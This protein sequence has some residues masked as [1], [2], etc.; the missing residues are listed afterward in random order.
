[1]NEEKNPI[2]NNSSINSL[3]KR[4]EEMVKMNQ[5]LFFDVDDFENLIDYYMS[6]SKKHFTEIAIREALE[7]HPKHNGFLLKKAQHLIAVEKNMEALELLDLLE[8]SD[9]F[10][11][12]VFFIK[13]GLYSQLNKFSLAIEQYLKALTDENSSE[14]YT[15]IAYEYENLGKYSM[16]IKYLK[17]ALQHDVEDYGILY[18]LSFCF[19]ITNKHEEGIAFF[20]QF[21]D[22]YPFS[23]EAWY[24]LGMLYSSATYYEQAID[25][26]DYAL[27]IDDS[28]LSVLLSKAHAHAVSGN[29]MQSIKTYKEAIAHDGD[30]ASTLYLIGENYSNLE[31]YTKA[32]EYFEE[33]IKLDANHTDAWAGIG[34][35]KSE[36]ELPETA[37]KYIKKAIELEPYNADYWSMLAYVQNQAGHITRAISSYEKTLELDEKQPEVWMDYA[38]LLI[39]NGFMH[40][41]IEKMEKAV[42]VH[43][44]NDELMY[45]AAAY[46]ILAGEEKKAL[47]KLES[48]L[49]LNVENFTFFLDYDP[50]FRINKDIVRLIES[51]IEKSKY[52]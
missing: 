33:C 19:E 28:F 36:L 12:E 8:K 34:I 26:Y 46:L 17:K 11:S 9:P 23:K 22:Q 45:R 7:Q 6:R 25:S 39:D 10:N 2:D 41:A 43:P 5:T 48:A 30:D 4:F 27:A 13:G 40:K 51:Y 3:R 49:E 42:K 16:A 29:Y 37:S 24:N 15:N 1:M 44:D 35:A 52:Y 32:I 18:E 31:K 14:V 47:T 20:N 50:S 38:D 21:L